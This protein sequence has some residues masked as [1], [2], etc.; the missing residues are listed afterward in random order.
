LSQNALGVDGLRLWVAMYGCENAGDIKLGP[1]TIKDLEQ[2]I[3]Q[4]RNLLRFILGSLKD[5]QGEKPTSLSLLD[6]VAIFIYP[7]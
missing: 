6:Q 2:R 5:Y 3:F 4:L 7:N 1:S